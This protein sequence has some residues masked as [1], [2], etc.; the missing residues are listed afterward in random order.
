MPGS[1]GKA[2]KYN[3]PKLKPLVWQKVP[4]NRLKGTIWQDIKD[5]A[6]DEPTFD[7]ARFEA[8]FQSKPAAKPAA[9]SRGASS[10]NGLVA[11]QLLDP[12]RANNFAI[13]LHRLKLPWEAMRRAVI[14]LDAEVLSQDAVAAL[15]KCV[16]LP[17]ELEM[18][19]A[20]DPANLGEME[21]YV[22]EVGSVPRFQQRLDCFAFKHRFNGELHKLYDEVRVVTSASEQLMRCDSLRSL[23]GVLLQ[24]GNRLNQGSF[25][26]GAEGFKLECLTRLCEI[27]TNGEA[28]SLLQHAVAVAAGQRD[29]ASAA[30]LSSFTEQCPDVRPA[31]KLASAELVEEVEKLRK[32]LE[33]IGEELAHFGKQSKGGFA[34]ATADERLAAERFVSVMQPFYDGSLPQMT[35]LC[36]YTSAMG[37]KQAVMKTYFSED[38]K[39]SV[40]ECYSRWA[41]FLS[42]VDTAVANHNEDVRKASRTRR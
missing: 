36:C 42:Q 16:P 35:E 29:A 18:V 40:D 39:V 19:R 38:S 1:C 8:L 26:S 27:K 23:L 4:K 28:S 14:E 6:E 22:L 2:S 34:S 32:G 15:Q 3:G 41:T 21:R 13:T 24:M 20:A 25:R 9:L 12:K 17:E 11:S 10:S 37:E 5:A 30:P 33:V 31:A 7:G